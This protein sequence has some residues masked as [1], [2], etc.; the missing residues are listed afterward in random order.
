MLKTYRALE[1]VEQAISGA[2]DDILTGMYTSTPTLQAR[3]E[4]FTAG[5]RYE[6]NGHLLERIQARLNG[7]GIHGL[8]F[9]VETFTKKQEHDVGADLASVLS[10]T[11]G[12]VNITKAFLA[13]AKVARPSGAAFVASSSDTLSQ[14]G[15]MLALSSDS[16]FLLYAPTQVFVVPAFSVHLANKNRISTSEHYVHP[17][18]Q[19]YAEF[20]KCYIGDHKIPG[21]MTTPQALADWARALP[22]PLVQVVTAA[23]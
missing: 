23:A 13:Q 8:R 1:E 14:A 10:V 11:L 20:F 4:E 19:F 5:L 3:E 6:V 21:H 12:N 22:A 17:L 18:G 7:R 9:T 2:V 15:H 16:F